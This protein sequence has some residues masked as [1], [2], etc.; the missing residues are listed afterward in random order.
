MRANITGISEDFEALVVAREL[1]L[2][3]NATQRRT[4]RQVCVCVRAYQG[5]LVE[6]E[7]LNRRFLVM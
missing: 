4:R 6:R 3:M 1:A 7:S 5:S 2:G